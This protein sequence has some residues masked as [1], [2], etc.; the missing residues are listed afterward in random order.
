MEN[1]Y[2]NSYQ[3][4]RYF[5]FCELKK[6]IKKYFKKIMKTTFTPTKMELKIS[7]LFSF[8]ENYEIWK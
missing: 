3:D 6:G 7:L 2:E 5:N 8:K 1:K 4:S